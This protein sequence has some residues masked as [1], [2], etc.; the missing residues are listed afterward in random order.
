MLGR[1][2][3]FNLSGLNYMV[4]VSQTL[5]MFHNSQVLVYSSFYKSQSS[6]KLNECF[7]K[8]FLLN[9]LTNCLCFNTYL[10]DYFS[11]QISLIFFQIELSKQF[12]D[13]YRVSF[14]PHMLQALVLIASSSFYQS[15]LPIY[16]HQNSYVLSLHNDHICLSPLFHYLYNSQVLGNFSFIDLQQSD[17]L[18]IQTLYFSF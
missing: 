7:I 18:L 2:S 12:F 5:S 13:S 3:N 6:T 17:S 4:F 9:H 11:S 8:S 14:D 16:V 10:N 1:Y 15:L